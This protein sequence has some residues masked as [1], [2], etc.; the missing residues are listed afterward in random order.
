MP[1]ARGGSRVQAK[2]QVKAPARPA[3]R[4]AATAAAPR[5]NLSPKHVLMIAG[6]VLALALI[7][8][9]A[10]GE[11]GAT[12]AQSVGSGFDNRLGD[13]GFRVKAIHVEGASALAKADIIKAAGVGV[14]QPLLGLDLAQVRDKVGHVGW[15][16]E[17]QVVRLL[18]DT[19]V[20]TV[21]ERRQLAVWQHGGR[22]VV[23]DEH[24][25]KIPEA[26]PARFTTLPLVVGAG[27]AKHAPDILPTLA[28][29][30]KL[31]ARMEALIRVDDRRWDLRLKDGSLIQLPAVDQDAALMKLEELDLRSHILDLGFERIDLRNPDVMTVRPRPVAAATPSAPPA[32]SQSPA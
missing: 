28:Q 9:L 1:A 30:P 16:Q 27:G 21:K 11:R 29:R 4:P 31:M 32:Q 19:L 25:Q 3:K 6:G 15:V 26:D 22:T 10:T 2:P 20:I 18:P 24:G 13:A 5:P 23:I 12:I 7:V 14:G 8:T 17:A